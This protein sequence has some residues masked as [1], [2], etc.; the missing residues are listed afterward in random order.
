MKFEDTKVEQGQVINKWP[1][2]KGK[3]KN[4]CQNTT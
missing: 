3:T 1:K 4:N 2:E